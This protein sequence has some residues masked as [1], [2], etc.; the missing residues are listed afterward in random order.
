MPF[1]YHEFDGEF[2]SYYVNV[3]PRRFPNFLDTYVL[4]DQCDEGTN[5]ELMWNFEQPL[6]FGLVR[7][8]DAVFIEHLSSYEACRFVYGEGRWNHDRNA[9][10]L[11]DERYDF[12]R[13]SR[14]EGVFA[15]RAFTEMEVRDLIL[16]KLNRLV[17]PRV[18]Y[19]S[20]CVTRDFSRHSCFVTS[21]DRD[22]FE[23]QMRAYQA[24]VIGFLGRKDAPP[25]IENMYALLPRGDQNNVI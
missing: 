2:H 12:S 13:Y 20:V 24:R 4:G 19:P 14:H 15:K 7:R 25:V 10:E 6:C 1:L 23:L 18:W 21:Y 3:D 5:I 22:S 11:D 9:F 8:A 16:H 17:S